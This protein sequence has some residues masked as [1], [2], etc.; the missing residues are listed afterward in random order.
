MIPAAR[1]RRNLLE[2]MV[3]Q[4]VRI[5]FSKSGN[6]KYIGHKDLLRALE[7]LFRRARLPLAM[8]NGYHPKVRMSF[9]SA[10]ALGVEGFDEVL[11]LE[12]NESAPLVDPGAL[13]AEL[14]RSSIEGLVFL[15]ARRL[16]EQDKKA[17]LVVSVFEVVVPEELRTAAAGRICSFSAES[18]VIVAKTNGKPVDVRTAVAD[19]RYNEESGLLRAEILTQ[20]GPEAGVRELLT[21]LELDD[22]YFKT[23]FPTRVL[24]RLADEPPVDHS[25]ADLFEEQVHASPPASKGNE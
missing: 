11:E 8:S 4:R 23:V 24:C 1:R 13:L 22:Q 20:D 15:S 16:G 18:S 14:N 3:R 2:P 5:R 9:P 21:A 7:S 19:L 17:R 25:K 12:L 10:L 6:L